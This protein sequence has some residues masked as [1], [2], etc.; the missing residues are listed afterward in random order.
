[1]EVLNIISDNFVVFIILI[2]ILVINF[3]CILFLI[4]K[5][6]KDD[7]QEIKEILEELN[8]KEEK[9]NAEIEEQQDKKLEQNKKEVEDMLLKMQKD[10]ETKPEDVVSTFENEQEEKSII[11]YQELLDS[12]KNKKEE[13]EVKVTPVKIEPEKIEIDDDSMEKTIIIETEKEEPEVQ[14]KEPIITDDIVQIEQPTIEQ[15]SEDQKKFKGTEFISPI[16]GKVE[17]NVKYPTVP[18]RKTRLDNF[19]VANQEKSDKIEEPKLNLVDNQK[20]NDDL[21]KNDDFLKAL[22]EF[23]KNLN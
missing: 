3:F 18:K 17:N 10:L 2:G 1:M 21:K 22:K 9:L 6:R 23:R 11:S 14:I 4:I 15:S 12:V 20:L 16:F 19:V 7:K 5:E 8:P 13:P